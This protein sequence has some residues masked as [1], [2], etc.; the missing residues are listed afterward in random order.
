M[1]RSCIAALLMASAAPAAL[2]DEPRQAGAHVHGLAELA[3]AL[4]SDGTLLAELESPLYNLAGFERAPRNDAEAALVRAAKDALRD[5]AWPA[6]NSEAGCVFDSVELEGFP[7]ADAPAADDEHGAHGDNHPHDHDHGHAH[8]DDHHHHGD[9]HEHEDYHHG[10][11]D[12]HHHGHDDHD[13]DHGHSH[14]H[15]HDHGH[16]HGGR[17]S[18]G[19]VTWGFTCASP[20]RLTA[21][22]TAALFEAFER[23]ER[24]N[25]QFFDGTRAASGTLTPSASR[26]SI[27]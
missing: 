11:G 2:A 5:G 24:V 12:D 22:D 21:I 6:F 17:Y 23:L 27:R 18:D 10:A 3:I 1:K 20:A 8:D 9:D 19:F 4:D 16:S 15:S 7:P 13:H 26:L 14:G 25:V